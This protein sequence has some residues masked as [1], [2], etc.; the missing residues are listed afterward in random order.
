MVIRKNQSQASKQLVTFSALL[1]SP[2]YG[3]GMALDD[4]TRRLLEEREVKHGLS[5]IQKRLDMGL[6]E[7]DREKQKNCYLWLKA[8]QVTLWTSIAG[9]LALGSAAVAAL[10]VAFTP[11]LK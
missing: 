8:R 2:E 10:V 11:A 9:R 1:C 7:F 6:F 4:R 5:V 3:P